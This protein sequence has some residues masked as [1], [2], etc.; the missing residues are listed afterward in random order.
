MFPHEYYCCTR[1]LWYVDLMKVDVKIYFIPAFY[2][3]F[4]RLLHL[5]ICILIFP[6]ELKETILGVENIIQIDFWDFG[7]QWVY[8]TTHQSFLSKR[9][10]FFLV[11]NLAKNL[12][13]HVLEE[14]EQGDVV[15]KTVLGNT[16]H[17]H[18]LILCNQIVLFTEYLFLFVVLSDIGTKCFTKKW[19]GWVKRYAAI[20]CIFKRTHDAAPALM[21]LGLSMG[22]SSSQI[23]CFS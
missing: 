23:E 14:E 12:H 3:T 16:T 21:S 7:G 20:F 22:R 8:Y 10:L 5:L 15:T 2:S 17:I 18:N 13:E 6:A 19:G 4:H 1:I 11:F 9:C